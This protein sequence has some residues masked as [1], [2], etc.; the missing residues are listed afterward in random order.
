VPEN[1]EHEG[2]ATETATETPEPAEAGEDSTTPPAPATEPE[3]EEPPEEQLSVKPEIQEAINRRIGREVAKTKKERDLREAAEA[4]VKELEARPAE[5]VP[6]ASAGPI[7]PVPLASIQTP[8]QLRGLADQA[9]AALDQAENLLIDLES[10]SA[11]VIATLL[12]SKIELG[13]DP[14]ADVAKKFLLQV[15]RNATRMLQRDVPARAAYLNAAAQADAQA[16]ADFPWWK[17][18]KSSQ[19]AQAQRVL[20]VLPEIKRLP[21][22][23][24]TTGVYVE[25]LRAVQARKV[26]L[27]RPKAKPTSQPTSVGGSPAK[28]TAKNSAYEAARAKWLKNPNDRQA[29]QAMLAEIT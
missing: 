18:T 20:A 7:G 17:D 28:P 16:M 24:W 14:T 1:A 25:G 9:E 29:R 5:S 22:W 12:A 23:K 21:H 13:Q 3:G 11:K 26:T 4:R 19:Y 2:S 10:E 15:R 8:E 6:A 27:P